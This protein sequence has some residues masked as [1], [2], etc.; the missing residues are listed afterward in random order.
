MQQN[1]DRKGSILK[2]LTETKQIVSQLVST[3]E[4]P[5]L[6]YHSTFALEKKSLRARQNPIFVR[7]ILCFVIRNL[8]IVK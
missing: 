3:G 1:L 5:K 6:I 8:S 7:A 4:T 2:I